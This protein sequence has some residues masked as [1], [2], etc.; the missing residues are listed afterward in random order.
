MNR[1]LSNA[2]DCYEL[3]LSLWKFKQVHFPVWNS[4][5]SRATVKHCIAFL[6]VISQFLN[7]L[8]LQE[9][10]YCWV[11]MW[12]VK[13]L[14]LTLLFFETNNKPLITNHQVLTNSWCH[15]V[16]LTLPSVP[17]KALQGRHYYSNAEYLRLIYTGNFF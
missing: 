15:W 6:D 5:F 13:T 17:I 12:T 16:L 14:I 11:K 10:Y 1:E 2:N 3:F 9:S 4:K 8:T 7:S